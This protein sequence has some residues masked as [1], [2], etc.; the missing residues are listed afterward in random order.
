MAFVSISLQT[1]KLIPESGDL[2]EL[3]ILC[4][5]LYSHQEKIWVPK[6]E[7]FK[8]AAYLTSSQVEEIIK[9]LCQAKTIISWNGLG[10]D[11]Q[12]LYHNCQSV[13]LKQKIKKIARKHIDLAFSFMCQHGYMLS[14]SKV[15][16][17]SNVESST[18]P[19]LWQASRNGQDLVI[20][21]CLNKSKFLIQ[22]YQKLI[23]YKQIEYA[24]GNA[25]IIWRPIMFK[26]KPLSVKNS[27]IVES[28]SDLP[29][30]LKQVFNKD[31]FLSWVS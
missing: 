24:S 27:S 4:L 25:K 11:L 7:K 22:L 16:F 10:F 18:V 2:S 30:S 26:D 13:N 15:G 29:D 20:N 19:L 3:K 21:T 17:E 14:L 9:D 31:K 6:N 23:N 28:D 8:R 12:I 5:C 1:D